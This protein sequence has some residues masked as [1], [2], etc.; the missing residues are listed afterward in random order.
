VNVEDDERSCRPRSHRTE[1]NV[2]KGR[3]LVHSDKRL[4]IIAVAVWLNLDNG[5]VRE[6]LSTWNLTCLSKL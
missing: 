6:S 1:E 4:S 2:E 3:N 5:T